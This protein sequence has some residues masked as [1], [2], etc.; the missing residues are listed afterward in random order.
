MASSRPKGYLGKMAGTGGL[1]HWIYIILKVQHTHHTEGLLRW[2]STTPKIRHIEG[3]PHWRPTTLK[4][5]HTGGPT[6]NS[7]ALVSFLPISPEIEPPE[8]LSQMSRQSSSSQ[9]SPTWNPDSETFW[10]LI[11]H[12]KW[13]IL[14]PNSYCRVWLAYRCIWNIK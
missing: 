1:S 12:H 13:K 7:T 8:I 6:W 4:V 11:G 2:R 9:S 3:P 14:H 5:H 10:A